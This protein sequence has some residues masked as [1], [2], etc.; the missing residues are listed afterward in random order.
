MY[1]SLRSKKAVESM[2]EDRHRSVLLKKLD[3]SYAVPRM[4]GWET[5]NLIA[6]NLRFGGCPTRL[7]VNQPGQL[8]IY[9]CVLNLCCAP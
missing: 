3:S 4:L 1:I 2:N 9:N 5:G 7:V 8:F 6:L